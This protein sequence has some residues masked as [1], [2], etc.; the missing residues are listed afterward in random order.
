LSLSELIH[1]LVGFDTPNPF[2]QLPP[3][4]S[5]RSCRCPRRCDR[6]EHYTHLRDSQSISIIPKLVICIQPESWLMSD[7][8]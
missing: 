4:S 2:V 7:D 3:P 6:A 5:C 8:C 1:E